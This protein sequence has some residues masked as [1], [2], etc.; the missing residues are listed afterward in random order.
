[1]THTIM[2]S[3]KCFG[4][5]TSALIKPEFEY[6]VGMYAPSLNND[7][8]YC[9]QMVEKFDNKMIAYAF[10]SF[11]NGGYSLSSWPSIVGEVQE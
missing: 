3:V 6:E 8:A 4:T 1:M 11:L 10:C 5:S 7:G 2:R 9:W